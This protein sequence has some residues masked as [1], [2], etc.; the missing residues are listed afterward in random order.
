ME[1]EGKAGLENKRKPFFFKLSS[2]KKTHP[3]F[4]LRDSIAA[5]NFGFYS[6]GEEGTFVPP[7]FRYLKGMHAFY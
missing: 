3:M 5:D 6:L 4:V 2:L 7:S 1:V